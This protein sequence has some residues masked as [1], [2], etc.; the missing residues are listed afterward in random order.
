MHV[1]E[2]RRVFNYRKI[3]KAFEGIVAAE[4]VRVGDEVCLSHNDYRRVK[5]V[6]IWHENYIDINITLLPESPTCIVKHKQEGVWIRKR[7]Y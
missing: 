3:G 2:G 5:S 6:S 4:D 1:I 7:S